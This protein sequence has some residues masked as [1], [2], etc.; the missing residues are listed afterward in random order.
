MGSNIFLGGKLPYEW[1]RTAEFPN[2]DFNS[3][4]WE[5]SFQ[6]YLEFLVHTQFSLEE[7]MMLGLSVHFTDKKTISETLLY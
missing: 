5:T 4:V 2:D 6:S 1:V 7:R 3:T